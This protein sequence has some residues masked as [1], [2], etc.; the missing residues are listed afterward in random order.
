MKVTLQ[1][2]PLIPIGILSSPEVI[3]SVVSS[4]VPSGW[5]SV[6]INIHGDWG[7]VH[8]LRGIGQIILGCVLS[9]RARVVPLGTLLLRGISSEGS[10]SSKHILE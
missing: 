9:L 5:R 3:A 8:P 7:V 10:I 4:V 6:S 1:A 2:I